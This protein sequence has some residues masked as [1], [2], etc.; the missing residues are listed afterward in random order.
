MSLMFATRWL[1]L[2]AGASEVCAFTAW[3][4]APSGNS[5]SG[6]FLSLPIV[7]SRD[8]TLAAWCSIL[9]RWITSKSNF[10]KQRDQCVSRSVDMGSS[11]IHLVAS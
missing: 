1:L 8:F 7:E 10:E 9:V 5:P 4:M 3:S 2:C 11:S 6:G